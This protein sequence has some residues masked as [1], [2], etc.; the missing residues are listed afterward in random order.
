MHFHLNKRLHHFAF[1][2]TVRF[3]TSIRF[4]NALFTDSESGK[5]LNTAVE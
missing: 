4:R 2:L 5:T 3:D 1:A